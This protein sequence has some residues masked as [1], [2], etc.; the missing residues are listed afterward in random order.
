MQRDLPCE[1]GRNEKSR[2]LCTSE[3]GK[4]H[5]QDIEMYVVVEIA[6]QQF[7]VQPDQRIY[8][9]RL[10]GTVGDAVE[11]NQVLLVDHDNAVTVG[12]PTVAGA[13][14]KAKILD[15]V[16]GDKVIVFKKKRRK[17]YKVKRGHRQCFTK[18]AISEIVA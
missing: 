14:V 9:H 2:Y 6:G 12:T 8:V 17:G 11:F 4:L 1:F 3:V 15:H 16:K 10:A 18:I 7:K 13:V 5:I